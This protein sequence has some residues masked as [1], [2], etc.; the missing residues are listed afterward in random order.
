M[1]SLQSER[2]NWG[3]IVAAAATKNICGFVVGLHL[4]DQKESHRA[5]SLIEMRRQGCYL[6]KRSEPIG[7]QDQRP[8]EGRLGIS[9]SLRPVFSQQTGK[10]AANHPCYEAGPKVAA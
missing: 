3:A 8:N 1:I 4:R 7:G 9:K 5:Q 2:W 10:M 6:H